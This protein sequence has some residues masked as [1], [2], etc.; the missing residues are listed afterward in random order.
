MAQ[1]SKVLPALSEKQSLVPSTQMSAHH[2]NSKEISHH[3]LG[4][5]FAHT[6]T[7]THTHTQSDK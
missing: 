7:H 5:A 6:H 4:A 1:Q 3:P 2:C